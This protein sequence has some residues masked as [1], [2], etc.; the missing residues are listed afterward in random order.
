MKIVV[1]T[2][3][4]PYNNDADIQPGSPL[5]L[6]YNSGKKSV[7]LNEVFTLSFASAWGVDTTPLYRQQIASFINTGKTFKIQHDF[8]IRL[9][10]TENIIVNLPT[11]PDKQTVL[12]Q[13]N[14]KIFR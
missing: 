13:T 3:F 4:T 8:T 7:V 1:S 6:L 5:W 11:V 9:R 14:F 12:I 10:F 2:T